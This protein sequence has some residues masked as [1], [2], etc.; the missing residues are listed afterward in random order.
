MKIAILGSTGLV[1][2]KFIKTLENSKHSVEKI[3]FFASPASQGKK[4]TFR[5]NTY[6]VDTISEDKLVSLDVLFISTDE[7]LSLKW[8]PIALNHGLYVIDN[9]SAFRLSSHPLII[10]EVNKELISKTA[11]I[12]A[13]PNCSTIQLALVLKA[14]TQISSLSSVHVATY[15]SVSGAGTAAIEELLN[16]SHDPENSAFPHPIS[17]TCIPQIG[18]FD[19]F[20]LSSE[21]NKIQNETKKILNLPDLKISAFCVR[22]PTPNVHGEAVWVEFENEV[23]LDQAHQALNNFESIEL[24]E[25][26]PHF[27]EV[28][29]TSE[30]YVSRV[31]KDLQNPKGLKLWVC[32]DNLLK[33]AA[34]NSFQ[35]L[36]EI[37][38]KKAF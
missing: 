11:D 21:E 31:H 35:I 37:L 2:Q 18:G 8:S 20:G 36:E 14:L 13:N 30:V 33:G 6:T 3:L 17:G 24:R 10:P 32:A 34:W 22:V 7:S 16:N 9:S 15:Q 19:D 27:S 25:H 12:I 4:I 1:G 26:Y 29:G 28:S 5:E 23:S 38:L